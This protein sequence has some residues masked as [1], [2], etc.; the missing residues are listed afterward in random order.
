[1]QACGS[2][3]GFLPHLFTFTVL[4]SVYVRGMPHRFDLRRPDVTVS[5]LVQ[6]SDRLRRRLAQAAR[7]NGR[8]LNREVIWRLSGSFE[9]PTSILRSAEALAEPPTLQ[10]PRPAPTTRV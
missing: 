8:S 10:L 6:M 5:L 4:S 2:G 1:M 3:V 9:A 7:A